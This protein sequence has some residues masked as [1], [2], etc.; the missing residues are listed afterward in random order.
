MLRTRDIALRIAEGW[1]RLADAYQKHCRISTHEVHYG[2]L[3]Y[4]EK[5][6]RLLGNVRGKRTLEIGCGGGQNSVALARQGAKAFGID[7]S[8]NQIEYARRL[9]DESGVKATFKVAGAEDLS[10][11]RDEFFDLALS[12]HAFGYVGDLDSAY[13]EAARVLKPS[14]HFVLCIGNPFHLIL[15]YR[16]RGVKDESISMDYLSWPSL[17]KWTWAYKGGPSVKMW[18]FARTLSQTINPL[19]EHGFVLERFVEQGVLDVRRMSEKEKSK[20]PYLC[21]WSEEE[22]ALAKEIP[23][24]FIMKMRKSEVK[25]RD[26]RSR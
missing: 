8:R 19:I 17:E 18:G 7:P 4:G 22:F 25:R 23:Y 11:F 20:I 9:A 16:I 12:S 5:R 6:L 3:T 15:S 2:P 21:G 1:D 14:G 10:L 26:S 24:S 13:R